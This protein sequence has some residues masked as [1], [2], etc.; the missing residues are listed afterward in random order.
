MAKI[1]ELLEQGREAFAGNRVYSAPYE[2]NGVTL[3]TASAIRGGLGG[4][5]GEGGDEERQGAGSGGG[6]GISARPVGAYLIKDD[7]VSWI[8]AA[9]TTRVIVA[10]QVVAIVG[11]LVLRSILKR[12][13]KG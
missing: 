11:L 5:E 6:F 9:D 10:T 13:R 2:R 12:R 8:P 3:I 1:D 7:Q 4:G